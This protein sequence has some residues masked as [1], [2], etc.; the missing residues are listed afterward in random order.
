MKR[1]FKVL[2]LDSL[3][4]EVVELLIELLDKLILAGLVVDEYTS[5]SCDIK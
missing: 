2:G 1:T 4:G 5:T 3:Y